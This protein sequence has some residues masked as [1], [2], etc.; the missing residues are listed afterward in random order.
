[1]ATI[2]DN[3]IINSIIP[4]MVETANEF[5]INGQVYDK[6]SLQPIKFNTLP[7]TSDN[8]DTCLNTS[9][10]TNK[11]VNSA[12]FSD[13]LVIVDKFKP[14]YSFTIIVDR[15][16][17]IRIHKI[18]TEDNKLTKVATVSNDSYSEPRLSIFSQ[19][20]KFIYGQAYDNSGAS[21]IF[22]INKETCEISFRSIGSAKSR[23]SLIKETS[24]YVYYAYSRTTD[25]FAIGRYNKSANSTSDIYTDITSTNVSENTF[26]EPM[27]IN[28]NEVLML[29]ANK[30]FN[31]SGNDNY[32][33]KK[34]VIDYSFEKV[35]SKNIDLDCSLL[36]N[37]FLTRIADS[38][39]WMNCNYFKNDNGN[40][41]SLWHR[42]SKKLYLAKQLSDSS[43]KIIQQYE[44]P[45]TY[46]GF[47]PMY[48][49][50]TLL[51]FKTEVIDFM[52]FKKAEERYE[53]TESKWG[54][55]ASLSVDKNKIIWIHGQDNNVEMIALNV[56]T[57]AEA[58]FV[59]TELTYKNEDI[60][61]LIEV[62]C[63]NFS[64]DLIETD[65][66]IILTGPV[67]FTADNS[68][69]K[70]IR[71]SSNSVIQVPVTITD[72]GYVETNTFIL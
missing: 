23:I 71:T 9:A 13:N 25:H 14:E 61:T 18:L 45:Q 66:E 31:P 36:P 57:S 1:M 40:Y 69:R 37:G 68:K 43:Y 48:N 44:L 35:Y 11:A 24:L 72:S 46:N 27:V 29:R 19:D 12:Y 65:I 54:Y 16:N 2:L 33:L 62:Y 39:N 15:S 8:V 70:K 53:L 47:I 5:V 59:D 34:Y 32:I 55:F 51:F 64:G 10:F 56:P 52:S 17:T 49:G 60:N 67:K 21:Y 42:S 7:L 50:E 28:E 3:Q 30:T 20:V 22:R 38:V 63:K 26:S 58:L 6:S 4:K 41:F